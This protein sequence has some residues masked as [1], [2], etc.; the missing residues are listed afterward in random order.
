[1][2]TLHT[3]DQEAKRLGIAPKTLA[4]W[5]CK[6][7]GPPFLKLGTQVRYDPVLTDVWLS[8]CEQTSGG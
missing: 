4:N 1:M 6:G 7:E 5:R 3:A 2:R 8:C